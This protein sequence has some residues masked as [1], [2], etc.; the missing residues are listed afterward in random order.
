MKKVVLATLLACVVIASGVS[1]ALAQTNASPATPPAAQPV[2]LG[3]QPAAATCALHDAEYTAYS[4]ALAQGNPQAKATGIEKYLSDFPTSACPAIR[5]STMVILMTAYSQFDAGKTLDAADRIL[6]LDPNNLRALYGEAVLRKSAADALTDP[7]AKQAL[8]DTAA[9]YARKGI[10]AFAAPKPADMPDA[11]FQTLKASATPSFYSI[12]GFAA[13]N[14]NDTATAIDAYKKE[15]ASVSLAATK[16]PGS[17]LMDTFYLAE[18]YSQSTRPDYLSC[19][20]Y[21]SRSVAYAPD[22]FKTQM[23]PIAKYCYKEY[24]DGDDGYEAMVASATA[25]L[26]PP[27]G[28][29]ATIKPG[30]TH[31][32]NTA[33]PTTSKM[34]NNEVIQLV[35]AGLSDQVVATSIRQA[36]N[37]DFD[38]TPTGLIALKKAGVSDAVIAAMQESGTAAHA[39]PPNVIPQPPPAP[40]AAITPAPAPTPASPC[41]DIDYLGVI[42]AVTGGGMMAGS[43]AYGGRVRNRASYTKEVDFAWVMN[44][45]AETGTFRVPAGQFIDVNLGVGSSPPTNVKVVTCR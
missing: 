21:A 43:N 17:V 3:A 38:L 33:S 32:A 4:N 30:L 26:N 41:A 10:A 15:L 42:Q 24:H 34:T 13:F 6:K 1:C 18:A 39:A 35:S 29:F 27:D 31:G 9:D 23:S 40:T 19:S 2:N 36:S 11:D 8:L 14:K 37:K 5:V 44:G 12:I 16:T 22:S 7:A 20:F 25:N 45:R 28:F